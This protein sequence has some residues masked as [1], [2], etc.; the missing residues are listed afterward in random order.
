[1]DVEIQEKILRL[2]FNPKSQRPPMVAYV[3]IEPNEVKRKLK[4]MAQITKF[5]GRY[6]LVTFWIT[7]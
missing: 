4:F 3:S 5:S 1:M 7:G 6:K 2:K